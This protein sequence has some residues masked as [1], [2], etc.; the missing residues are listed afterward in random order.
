MKRSRSLL[1]MLAVTAGLIAMVFGLR[2]QYARFVAEHWRGQLETVPDERAMGLLRGAAQLGEP[3]I[4]VLVEALG[5]RRERVARDGKRV[6]LD[7]VSRWETLAPQ[8]A[9]PKLAVLAGALAGRV[10]EFDPRARVDAAH[11]AA[12]ILRWPLQGDAV[13]RGEVIAACEKVLRTAGPNRRHLAERRP[14]EEPEAANPLRQHPAEGPIGPE[15]ATPSAG[16]SAETRLAEIHP[17]QPSEQFPTRPDR[18]GAESDGGPAG[19]AGREVESGKGEAPDLP[20]L[21]SLTLLQAARGSDRNAGGAD[22][23]GGP[24]AGVDTVELMR[25]L[26]ADDDSVASRAAAELTR[27]GFSE[28]H[29]QLA[30]QL[31]DPDPEIRKRL[32]RTLPELQTVDAVPWLLRLAR[33]EDSG[34]RLLAITLLATTGDPRLLDEIERIAREDPV[35]SV[36]LQGERI[37]RQRRRV[38]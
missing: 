31:F 6:L 7:E 21:R 16:S 34:V 13:D 17:V 5:S 36:Q 33:D 27:R 38:E 18:T 8:D 1:L 26:R 3:G 25:R 30:R 20:P 19:P 10:E 9:F 37:A 29:L 12:R 28:V 2:G 22:F 23:T 32:A 11:L 24:L 15:P 4:P 14:V 35:P